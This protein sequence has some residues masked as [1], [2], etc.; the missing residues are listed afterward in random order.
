LQIRNPTVS[1]SLHSFART[2][3]IDEDVLGLDVPVVDI[4]AFKVVASLGEL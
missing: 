1:K 2:F 4:L 3:G